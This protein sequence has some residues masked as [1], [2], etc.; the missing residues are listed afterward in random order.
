[1]SCKATQ[2]QRNVQEH[3]YVT[4]GNGTNIRHTFTVKLR[5]NRALKNSVTLTNLYLTSEE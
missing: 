1:M 5:R 2:E 3:Q 4:D